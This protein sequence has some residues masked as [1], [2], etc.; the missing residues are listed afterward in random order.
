VT[1]ISSLDLIR[2][3]RPRMNPA[4]PRRIDERELRIDLRPG[5][6]NPTAPTKPCGAE[7]LDEADDDRHMAAAHTDLWRLLNLLAEIAVDRMKSSSN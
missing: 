2:V 7:I 3:V 6:K 4:M 1:S 5:A